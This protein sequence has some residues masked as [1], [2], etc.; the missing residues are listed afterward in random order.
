[1]RVWE[2][3]DAI[4]KCGRTLE[5][6]VNILKNNKKTTKLLWIE[7]VHQQIPAEFKKCGTGA[8][9]YGMRLTSNVGID[10]SDPVIVDQ[11]GAKAVHIWKVFE[12]YYLIVS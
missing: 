7:V 3:F 6:I 5:Y 11:Y 1:M 4:F 8:I 12:L 10:A 2:I 9:W